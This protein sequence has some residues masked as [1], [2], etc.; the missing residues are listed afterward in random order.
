MQ[1]EAPK[2]HDAQWRGAT[3]TVLDLVKIGKSFRR[4]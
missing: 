1:V 2:P 3:M 4:R